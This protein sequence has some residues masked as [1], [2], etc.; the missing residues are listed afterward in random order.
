MTVA[1]HMLVFRN[2]LEARTVARMTS[3]DRARPALRALVAAMAAAAGT[4]EAKIVAAFFALDFGAAT[5]ETRNRWGSLLGEPRGG[6]DEATYR[7]WQELRIVVNTDDATPL[8]LLAL[9]ALIRPDAGSYELVPMPPNGIKAYV[10][11]GPP[12]PELERGHADQLLRDYQP[13]G[14]CWPVIE[15]PTAPFTF[16]TVFSASAGTTL[17]RLLFGGR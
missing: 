9:V 13:A 16:T 17:A 5:G 14:A 1:E 12:L 7:R 8:R 3:R 2:D 6:L 15:V 11:D 4:M 10:N